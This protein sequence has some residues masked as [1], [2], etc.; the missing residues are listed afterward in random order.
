MDVSRENSPERHK[1]EAKRP[2]EEVRRSSSPIEEIGIDNSLVDVD[3][4]K[5]FTQMHQEQAVGIP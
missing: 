3:F 5:V 4:P 1:G 2:V